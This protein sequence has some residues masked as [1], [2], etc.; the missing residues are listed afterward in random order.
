MKK[1]YV[2][3]PIYYIND[4]AHIGHIYCT[5][6]AD[7][8]AR[9]KRSMGFDVMFL[10]GT[11]ENA[12]KVERVAQ[13]KGIE[14][15]QFV[16][17]LANQW[18]EYF[19]EFDLSHDDFIRT[20]EPRH[21]KSAQEVFK[22]L[23]D[24]GDIYKGSYEGNYCVPCETH[25]LESDLVDGKCPD[26]GRPVEKISEE[27]YFFK[28][29]KYRD[30]LLKHFDENPDFVLPKKRFNEVYSVIKEGLRDVSFSRTGKDWGIKVPFDDKHTIYVWG[31]ALVNYLTGIGFPD[32]KTKF[33]RYWPADVHIVGKDIIR[34]HCMI[35]PAMLMSL[36][37]PL[38]KHIY[39]HGWWTINSEKVSKSKGNIV[40]PH[41]EVADLVS[42]SGV[43]EE[44]A[45]DAFRYFIFRELPF[46]D[47]GD[48]SSENFFGRYNADRANDLG[49]LLNRTQRMV[50][51][52]FD[53]KIPDGEI[54]PEIKSKFEELFPKYCELTEQFK[55]SKALEIIWEFVGLLNGSIE[56]HKPWELKKLGKHQEHANLLYTL[57]EGIL[58]TSSLLAPFIPESARVLAS[59]VG[60]SKPPELDNLKIGNIKIGQEIKETPAMFPRIDKKKLKP[61]KQEEKIISDEDLLSIED[62]A[63]L[64]L[65]IGKILSVERIEKAD[66]LLKIKVDIG[67]STKQIVAG[68]SQWYK[69]EE[70]VGK[71]VCVV[72]NLKP[73]KL[74]GVLSEGMLLAATGKEYVTILSPEKEVKPGSKV[75]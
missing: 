67:T 58:L 15:K 24:N 10:T 9:Y 34:F 55:F 37:L 21:V 73:A 61:Q 51:K 45:K 42:V 64:K 1:F 3:T 31:D 47:D 68:I 17:Q 66:K 14:T 75:K 40:R 49:N 54:L 41:E 36:G 18:K 56:I 8:I 26:C 13:A 52:S 11:D 59:S 71:L 6:S 16:D 46:G 23:H 70:L 63:K 69:P 35:W 32:D 4:K 19:K 62:F 44:L 38:P 33:E 12:T 72:A 53:G 27:N 65:K 20:T 57:L 2:T 28:L 22:R 74:R 7:I 30:K 60:F 5:M 48:F 43:N 39:A 50:I 29:T 25:F